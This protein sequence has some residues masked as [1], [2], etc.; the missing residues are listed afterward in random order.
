M[1]VNYSECALCEGDFSESIAVAESAIEQYQKQGR[2]FKPGRDFDNYL[3]DFN[4]RELQKNE[5][6][7]SKYETKSKI[8]PANGGFSSEPGNAGSNVQNNDLQ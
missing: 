8:R 6:R 1:G 3:D 4:P 2:P 5:A 7:N